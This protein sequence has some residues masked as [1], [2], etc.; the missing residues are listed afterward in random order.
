MPDI[1]LI[2]NTTKGKEFVRDTATRLR[3]F[4]ENNSPRT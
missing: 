1:F 2:H 3:Q 4:H